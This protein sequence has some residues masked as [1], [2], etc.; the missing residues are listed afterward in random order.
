[1]PEFKKRVR[2]G[3]PLKINLFGHKNSWQWTAWLS[4]RKIIELSLPVPNFQRIH[5]NDTEGHGL[6][7][8]IRCV[9]ELQGC[10]VSCKIK[11]RICRAVQCLAK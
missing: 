9:L 6:S 7:S 11:C 8:T 10:A 3:Y 2:T 4:S 5:P 1:M